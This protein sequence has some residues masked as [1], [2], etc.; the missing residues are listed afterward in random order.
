LRFGPVVDG[1]VLPST[2]AD[3]FAQGK[4]NDVPTLTG[5][6]LD[7][8]GASPRPEITAEGFEKQ[9]RTRFGELAAEFLA[10]YPAASDEQARNAQ[11]ESA[12]DQA[13][14]SM[15][16]WATNRAKTAQSKAFTYFFTHALPGPDVEKYGAFHTAEVPYVMGALAMS[17]RPFVEADRQLADLASSYWANFI[18]T[19]DPNGRGLPHWP[20]VGSDAMTFELGDRPAPIRVADAAKLAFFEKFFT[21]P[22]TVTMTR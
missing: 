1:Y 7:E 10:L 17:P 16:L 22:R 5:C 6:N 9:A 12:R 3:A 11:N 18:A 8:G 19:G 14:V 2:V 20:A 21:R 4:Q 15:Y 13:R